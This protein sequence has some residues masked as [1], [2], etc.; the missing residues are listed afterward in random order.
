MAVVIVSAGDEEL[1]VCS[2]AFVATLGKLFE[3]SSFGIN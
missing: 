1:A 3:L 2:D